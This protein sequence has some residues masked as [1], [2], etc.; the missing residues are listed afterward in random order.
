LSDN[1]IYDQLIRDMHF[2]NMAKDKSN[3][4]L[5][6]QA[7]AMKL[8]LSDEAVKQQLIKRVEK[9]LL[10]ASPPIEPTEAEL[11]ADFSTRREQFRLPAK[12]SIT[13][14]FFNPQQ[15]VEL[16]AAITAIDQQG[17]SVQ[18]ARYLSSPFM[19][20]YEFNR[21]TPAQLSRQFGAQFVSELLQTG[22]VAGQWLGPIRSVY[23]WHYVWLSAIEPGREAQF[24]DVEKQLRR[25]FEAKARSQAL[26]SAIAKL[27]N[28]YEVR[29]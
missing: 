14:L 25:D 11:R 2:L 9:R 16:E 5:F 4:E 17:L 6:E 1:I 19:S 7:L 21:Q 8:H 28:D 27:R 24:E 26:N 15:Q 23:G 18:A 22:S 29:L 12:L 10:I 3:A 20:G 13:H